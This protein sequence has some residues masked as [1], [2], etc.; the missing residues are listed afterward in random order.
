DGRRALFLRL[1]EKPLDRPAPICYA[2]R[3]PFR[4][5]AT[6]PGWAEGTLTNEDRSTR[7]RAP[8]TVRDR[9]RN[10]PRLATSELC[11]P[12]V[13]ERYGRAGQRDRHL[14]IRHR[15]ERCTLLPGER[16]DLAR[17][18]GQAH[19]GRTQKP[20]RVPDQV[21]RPRPPPPTKRRRASPEGD[22]MQ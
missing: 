10:P 6:P 14:R 18:D 9:P 19:Q 13:S 11:R 1:D 16:R 5:T 21:R 4:W 8:P 3:T 7:K 12:P 15:P 22:T 17:R 20:G 2:I